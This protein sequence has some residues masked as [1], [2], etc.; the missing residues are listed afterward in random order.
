MEEVA[1]QK[2]FEAFGR[3][4]N[5]KYDGKITLSQ[6]DKWLK[7]AGVIGSKITTTDTAI[8]FNKFKSKNIDYKTFVQFINTLCQD[9]RQ[10]PGEI[11]KKLIAVMPGTTNTTVVGSSGVVDRLTDTSKYTGS[12]KE[13]FDETGKGRGIE[14]RADVS[15]N[16]GYVSGYKHKGTYG[17]KEE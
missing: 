5:T 12:H 14:G 1:F 4:G 8:T 2:A 3:F 10:N 17:K 13:R 15:E 7:Q 16:D 11:T 6:I 9:K